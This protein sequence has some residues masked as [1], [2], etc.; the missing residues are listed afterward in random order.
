[1][2]LLEEKTKFS[3]SQLWA[4]QRA[5][6]EQKGVEA[7]SSGT[8]PHY[9]TSNPVVG[10]T[11]AELVL[12]FLRDLSLKK[13]STQT[14][15]L[16]ELGAGHGRFCYH[17]FKHFE[18]FYTQSALKLPPFC[19]VLSDFTTSNFEFW[20]THPRLGPY[21]EKGWLDLALFDAE[22]DTELKLEYQNKVLGINS[23]EQPLIVVANYFFDSIPQDLFK[24][25]NQQ[26]FDC[27]VSLH[28]ASDP[29]EQDSTELL[30]TLELVYE[31]QTT[32]FDAYQASPPIKK[33][34]EEYQKKL[35]NTHFLFP[36]VGLKCIERLRKL[37]KKGLLLLSADRGEHHWS[38]LEAQPLP[39]RAIHGSFSLA[40]NYHAFKTYCTQEQGLALFPLH[41]HLS[42]NLGCLLFL[43]EASSYLE[44]NNAY[45][46]FVNDYGPDDF[47][48]QKKFVEQHIED[49]SFRDIIATLRLSA[50]DA[51]IFLQ[52]SPHLQ[53]LI[54]SITD[55]E[56]WVLYQAI[57]RIWDSYYP[58][59]EDNKLAF[60]LGNLLFQLRFY[61]EA[62][63]YYD[64]S[65]KIYGLSAIVLYNIALSYCLLDEYS[66]A[67]PIIE[68]LKKHNPENKDLAMLVEKFAPVASHPSK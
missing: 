47:F 33:L 66:N 35:S 17:F 51:Q 57:H 67:L 41:Q 6:Y 12:A 26:L 40:V 42:L 32:K 56:R 23:L 30:A 52:I 55:H 48:I 19:Y 1:M 9:I 20:K 25:Q 39:T 43:P 65:L 5:Y 3:D 54:D 13:Q 22:K 45:E 64:F 60:E 4:L 59:G 15:Y 16:L 58:L 14:V 21:L 37:S 49:L 27:L 7:W 8:V 61:R 68:E 38:K 29:A 34:L 63:I 50:Y 2:F 36:K 28:T 44:T 10:K 11:Y 18:K 62:I 46:R 31:Y 24:V 53:G